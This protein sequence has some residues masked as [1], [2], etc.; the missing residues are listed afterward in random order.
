ME[1]YR[2][3]A[4][5]L[6]YPRPGMCERAADG[7][8]LLHA[9]QKE[10][11]ELLERF[12]DLVDRC[13]LERLEEMYTNAFEVQACWYPYVGHHLFG[14]D[15]RRGVFMAELNRCY[16]LAGFSGVGKE[17]PDHLSV[18]LRYL[19]EQR[20][21]EEGE[22]LVRECL[23]PAL[24]RMLQAPGDRDHPYGCLLRSLAR[25]LAG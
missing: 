15:W 2:I 5:L 25:L 24:S 1:L 11:A 12:K 20:R 8:K 22:D 23:I 17:L 4:E 6:D 19:A 21:S 10:S 3:F 9:C 13:P 16:R 14:E 18:M 7:L